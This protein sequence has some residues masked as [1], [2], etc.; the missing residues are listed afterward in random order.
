MCPTW[1][2]ITRRARQLLEPGAAVVLDTETTDLYGHTIELGVVDAATGKVLQATLVKPT[3][4]ITSGARYVHGISDEDV[5]DARPFE[6]VLPR[7]RK[8]TKDRVICAY[9][10]DFDRAVILGDV[11][12]AGKK[13]GHLKPRESW[14]CLMNAYAAWLGS[15]RWLRLGGGHRAAGDC[16]ATR[17][18][19]VRMSEGRGSAF[20]P[21]SAV[22]GNP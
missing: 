5:A 15:N 7:L 9:N 22:P 3:E 8:V 12:R 18:V 2:G 14:Y 6:K 21:Q 1:G 11:R 16:L 17:D 10:V 4:P 13:P 20:T 19:L